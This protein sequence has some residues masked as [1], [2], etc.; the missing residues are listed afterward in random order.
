MPYSDPEKRRESARERSRRY[1]AR[2]PEKIVEANAANYAANAEQRKA[3]Q[4]ARR[5]AM[6]PEERQAYDRRFNQER[7]ARDP[8]PWLRA[9]RQRRAVAHGAPFT[10][11][12][13]EYAILLSCDPCSYCGGEATTVDHIVP[14]S[15][16]GDSGASNLT[17]ACRPCNSAKGDQSLLMFLATRG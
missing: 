13:Q 16:G 8:Q 14:L 17:A 15:R 6:S 10:P 11:E 4:R 3:D 1:R 2:H 5:A 12:A 7:Y 9:T